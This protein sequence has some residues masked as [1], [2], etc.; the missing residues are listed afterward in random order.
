MATTIIEGSNIIVE[1]KVPSVRGDQGIP[2]PT[3]PQGNN[4]DTGHTGPTGVTGETGA[5]GPIGPVGATG[6][7]GATGSTGA[8]GPTGATGSTG[9]TG[10]TGS[11]G[12]TGIG[13]T[14]PTGAT[15]AVGATGPTGTVTSLRS[16]SY[17]GFYA[18]KGTA[19]N[20]LYAPPSFGPAYSDSVTDQITSSISY[21]HAGTPPTPN[22]STHSSLTYSIKGS[23]VDVPHN[24]SKIVMSTRGLNWGSATVT[25]QTFFMSLW[26]SPTVASEGT[27]SVTY[28][29]IGVAESLLDASSSILSARNTISLTG[30]G[31]T[32][33]SMWFGFGWKTTGPTAA[34]YKLNWNLHLYE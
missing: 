30:L 18:I 34:D 24:V 1:V 31:L 9:A 21:N 14:G 15:G 29:C 10:P 17:N 19:T 33:G 6:A 28:T 12:A 5:Q 20:T 26:H 16:S 13:V 2:G 25:N 27:G 32:G 8:T 4:G 23:L 22:S 3:G 11:T 7:T